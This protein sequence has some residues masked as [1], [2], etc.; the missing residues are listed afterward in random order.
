M[1]PR[2]PLGPDEVLRKLFKVLQPPRPPKFFSRDVEEGLPRRRRVVVG[3]DSK[4]IWPW[5]ITYKES[6]RGRGQIKV[7]KDERTV[8]TV[9]FESRGERIRIMNLLEGILKGGG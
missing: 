8:G 4:M 1:M 6:L 3:T 7:L 9:S 5:R 2:F